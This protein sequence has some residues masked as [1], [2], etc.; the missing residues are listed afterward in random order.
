MIR[1]NFGLLLIM[2]LVL[3]CDQTDVQS[4]IDDSIEAHGQDVFRDKKVSFTFRDIQYTGYFDNSGMVYTRTFED[5]TGMVNDT[6]INASTFTRHINGAEVALDEEWTGKYARSVNSVLYFVKIPLVANDPAVNKNLIGE[7]EIEGNQ[8]YAVA[9]TFDQEGGGED[10]E[11]QFR[12]WIN[13]ETKMLDYLA[14]NYQTDEG[15]TRFRKAINRR[16]VDGL[17]VQ[18]YINFEP[19][20]KYPDLDDLPSLFEAG[21]LKELSRIIN[22]DFQIQDL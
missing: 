21:Q 6:L 10:F 12:Y 14:Y 3:G 15:G 16:E 11:D 20:T 7:V 22:E 2:I 18:D 1:T 4:I 13:K 9:I 5:S 8:Y 19:P 17:V